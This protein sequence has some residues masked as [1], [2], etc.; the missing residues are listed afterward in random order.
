[1]EINRQLNIESLAGDGKLEE[2][3]V[4]L[5]QTY[6]QLEIDTAL[7]NAIAYS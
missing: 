4:L 1:M 6:T 3:I 7:E 5:G 2:L